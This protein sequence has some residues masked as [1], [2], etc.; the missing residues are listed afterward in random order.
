MATTEV[1]E[2]LEVR[3]ESTRHQLFLKHRNMTAG[4]LAGWIRANSATPEDAAENFDLSLAQV[5]EAL[6]YYAAHREMIDAEFAAE[7]DE[8]RTRGLLANQPPTHRAFD[9][10]ESR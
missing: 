9:A 1:Y 3:P 7:T 5:R 2:H 10:G 8:A 6:A 4:D